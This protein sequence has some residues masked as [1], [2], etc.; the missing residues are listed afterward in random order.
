MH[1][2]IMSD[3]LVS[4]FLNP[5]SMMREESR[6]S[7]LVGIKVVHPLETL[8]SSSPCDFDVASPVLGFP[9]VSNV[10]NVAHPIG[11]VAPRLAG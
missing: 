10:G 1:S 4:L 6:Q 5:A 9:L 2:H 8:H 3:H 11:L 7:G